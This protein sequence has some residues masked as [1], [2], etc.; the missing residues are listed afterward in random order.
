M[1]DAPGWW[2]LDWGT[3]QPPSPVIVVEDMGGL[4]WAGIYIDQ[5]G[6]PVMEDLGPVANVRG[7]LGPVAPPGSV[8]PEEH[9]RAVR[10]AH[11]SGVIAGQS[12]DSIR[13]GWER[14]RDRRDLI[15]RVGADVVEGVE[16]A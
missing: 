8:A 12:G 7:W 15:A 14:S 13:A 10:D 5:D 11:R 4:M 2:I 9:A 3:A 6:V 1:P 16:R